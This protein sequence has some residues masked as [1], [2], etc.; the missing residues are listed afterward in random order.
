M[1]LSL[2]TR[3]CRTNQKTGPQKKPLTNPLWNYCPKTRFRSLYYCS[4]MID[5]A[6]V[7]LR[8]E[9]LSF[10]RLKGDTAN[11]ILDNIALLEATK[12]DTLDDSVILSLVNIEEESTLKNQS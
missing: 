10:I 12:G 3:F 1:P 9:L 5:A 8:E 4:K 2:I 6:L 7:L 11:V